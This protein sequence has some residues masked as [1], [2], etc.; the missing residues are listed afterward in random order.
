M[1]SA[2]VFISPLLSAFRLIQGFQIPRALVDSAW[3]MRDAS[4]QLEVNPK[5]L[6]SLLSLD[7]VYFAVLPLAVRNNYA[8]D[9]TLSSQA[10]L[11]WNGVDCDHGTCLLWLFDLDGVLG[12]P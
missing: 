2:P 12:P 4:G 11:R 7:E 6:S 9:V 1:S 8:I 10:P 5:P 3:Q